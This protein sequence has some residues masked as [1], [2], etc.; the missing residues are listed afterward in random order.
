[1]TLKSHA[2]MTTIETRI[3]KIRLSLVQLKQRLETAGYEFEKPDV[4]LPGPDDNVDE[5]LARLDEIVGPI[6]LALSLFYRRIGSVNFLGQ[7]R[8]WEEWEGGFTDPLFV[9]PVGAGITELEQFLADRETYL[10][11]F[12]TFRLPIAP[13]DYHK[14]DVSGGMWYNITLPD[15]TEDP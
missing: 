8:D 2:F 12:G 14:A 3:E 5:D 13:D 6:P 15:T 9:F 7:H 11:A 1:T 4:A 10:D